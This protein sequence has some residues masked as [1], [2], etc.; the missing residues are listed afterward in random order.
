VRHFSYGT[1][2]SAPHSALLQ[3]W[4]PDPGIL[5][6]S[7]EKPRVCALVRHS[8]FRFAPVPLDVGPSGWAGVTYLPLIENPPMRSH[9]GMD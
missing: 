1:R 7:W 8:S 9:S 3:A 5:V 4:R 6:R 2:G